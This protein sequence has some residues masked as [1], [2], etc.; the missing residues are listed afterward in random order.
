MEIIHINNSGDIDDVEAEC[1]TY[2]I[3]TFN[4]VRW[5]RCEIVNQS[6]GTD[7]RITA[8]IRVSLLLDLTS[9]FGV[10]N[11]CLPQPNL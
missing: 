5:F 6:P 9:G 11:L 2:A 10:F 1:S 4:L 3:K 7:R 8:S